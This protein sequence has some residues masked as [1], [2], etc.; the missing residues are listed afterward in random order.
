M[1]NNFANVLHEIVM[2]KE[3][4]CPCGKFSWRW[5]APDQTVWF[6]VLGLARTVT[7][8]NDQPLVSDWPATIHMM[9]SLKPVAGQTLVSG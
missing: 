3:I 6:P 4:K 8:L 1:S 7:F 2:M 5:L 9:L